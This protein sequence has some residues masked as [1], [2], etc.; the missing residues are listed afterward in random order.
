MNRNETSWDFLFPVEVELEE[1]VELVGA[2]GRLT[3]WILWAVELSD[4][5]WPETFLCKVV[6]S[7]ESESYCENKSH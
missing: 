4:S 2:D 3:D 1:E 5:T 7:P 6:I